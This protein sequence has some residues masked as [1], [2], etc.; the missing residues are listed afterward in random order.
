MRFGFRELRVVNGWFRLNGKR[1]FLRS[2]HT[3]NHFPIGQQ[4]AVDH[5]LL[6][7][8]LVLAKAS[9]FNAVR[10]IAGVAWPEQLDFC[11]EIG[12]MVYEL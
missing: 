10:F 2:T 4:V 11:D 1:I 9:G 5:D 8:D 7:R 6:R 3:G 12:L